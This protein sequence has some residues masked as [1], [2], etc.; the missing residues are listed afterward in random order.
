MLLAGDL[1]FEAFAVPWLAEGPEPQVLASEPSTLLAVGAIA[2][3]LLFAA[4][5]V[6]FGLASLRARVFPI[7][8]SVLI[9]IGGI[10]GYSALLAP[11]GVPLGIAVASLGGWMMLRGTSRE[12]VGRHHTT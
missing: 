3:Y 1:W 5:W 7:A 8:I 2:S 11:F 10:A 9:V 12:E 6:L 4:G